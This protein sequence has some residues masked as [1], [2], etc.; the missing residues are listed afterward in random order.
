[1]LSMEIVP[2][3]HDPYKG[4]MVEQFQRTVEMRDTRSAILSYTIADTRSLPYV[5]GHL[6]GRAHSDVGP[7]S[8]V[9]A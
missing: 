9:A 3:L 1:M 8:D 7:L 4:G 6:R 2:A 5:K